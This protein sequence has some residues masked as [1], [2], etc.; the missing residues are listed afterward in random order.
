LV[1]W[2]DGKPLTWD[3]TVICIVA[4]SYVGGSAREAGSAAK[5]AALR[6]EAKYATLQRT[7]LF[8]VPASFVES[9]RTVEK[10]ISSFLTEL[11][12]R[13]SALSG[14]NVKPPCSNAFRLLFSD[15]TLFCCGR[16]F[17]RQPPG[18]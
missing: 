12:H 15:S 5:T 14:D 16:V 17:G 9:L 11:G 13:I 10:A 6:K 8:Q 3:T 7:H 1:P 4:D 18:R 2:K